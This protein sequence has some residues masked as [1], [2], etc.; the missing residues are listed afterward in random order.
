MLTKHHKDGDNHIF[1]HEGSSYSIEFRQYIFEVSLFDYSYL[2]HVHYKD[3][4][5][6]YYYRAPYRPPLYHN[7]IINLID[8]SNVA[9]P[10]IMF[11]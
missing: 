9:M 6:V 1:S 11:V 4:F 8:N 3:I 7:P 2:Q 5:S 10:V